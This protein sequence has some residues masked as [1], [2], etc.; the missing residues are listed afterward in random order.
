MYVYLRAYDFSTK[1]LPWIR[2]VPK[3]VKTYGAL[4]SLPTVLNRTVVVGKELPD[5]LKGHLVDCITLS[6]GSLGSCIDEE[7][8]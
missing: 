5:R 1:V 6:G 3:G 8:G 4:P 7:R 2:G